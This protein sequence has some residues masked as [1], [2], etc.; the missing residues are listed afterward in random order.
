LSITDWISFTL[1]SNGP[2]NLKDTLESGHSSF[3]IPV[4]D[5]KD[6]WYLA[7]KLPK[8]EKQ[9]VVRLSQKKTSSPIKVG[10]S[11]QKES[12]TDKEVNYLK[13]YLGHLF[14]LNIDLEAFYNQFSKDPLAPSF[15][16]RYGLRLTK[17]HDLFES[18]ICS[19]VTQRNSVWKWNG[20]IRR[21][22][23]LLGKKFPVGHFMVYS[24]PNPKMIV[25]YPKQLKEIRLGY[26]EEYVLEAAK[27]IAKKESILENLRK[28]SLGSARSELMEFKGIGPKVADMFLLYGL[29]KIQVPPIDV[30]IRRGVS[31]LL[32]KGK[33][34]DN[35]QCRE[36]LV[37]RYGEWA[38]LAQLYLYDWM[39]KIVKKE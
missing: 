32:F 6:Y 1:K 26:R 37:C 27:T 16:K 14:G 2:V 22:M 17:A 19:I 39:R 8:Y 29:G 35:S 28:S 12:F 24:F 13:D 4:R 18:L 36:E 5:K 11:P 21:L 38:G 33:E 31:K 23:K 34:I 30:W 15:K 20:Q 25:K 10:L 3:P 9:V 7:L